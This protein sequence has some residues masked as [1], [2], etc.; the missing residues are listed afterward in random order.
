MEG[1][2]EWYCASTLSG[3]QST[4]WGLSL[5]NNGNRLISCSDDKSIILWESISEGK[6]AGRMEE[7]KWMQVSKYSNAHS[8]PIY[9]VDWNESLG[10]AASCGGDNSIVLSKISKSIDDGCLSLEVLQ[11]IRESHEGDVNCVRWNPKY[12]ECLVSAGDDGRLNIW[13]LLIE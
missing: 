6:L 4:V 7:S 11:T 3:H 2:D 9:S 13:S 10:L 12:P 1:S 5:A 8:G